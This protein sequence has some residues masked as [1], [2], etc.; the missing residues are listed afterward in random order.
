MSDSESVAPRREF[1]RTVGIGAAAIAA[2]AVGVRAAGALPVDSP[3]DEAWLTRITGKHRQYFDAVSAN[4]GWPIAFATTFIRKNMEAYGL[5]QS[6]ITSIVG[7]RHMAVPLA[8]N[9]AMWSKYHIGKFLNITDKSTGAP[10]LRNTFYNVKPGDL[11]MPGLSID[12]FA[13]LGGFFTVC[14]AALTALSGMAAGAAGLPASGAKA[15]W[16][17]NLLP[18]FYIVPAGVLAVNRA[19]EYHCTYCYAG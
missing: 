17:S 12:Q 4:D 14:D 9:D 13:A 10:A 3:P 1:M 11:P 16:E 19:Q 8:L 2:S 5:K 6:E 15:E 18:H 7:F